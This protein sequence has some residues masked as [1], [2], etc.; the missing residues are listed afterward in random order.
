MRCRGEIYRAVNGSRADGP[1]SQQRHRGASKETATD[2]VTAPGLRAP[3]RICLSGHPLCTGVTPCPECFSAL[4]QMVIVPA[5]QA[6]DRSVGCGVCGGEAT[7]VLTEESVP[8]FFKAYG[9]KRR[10]LALRAVEALAS[11][12]LITPPPA[13]SGPGEKSL[14]G[15]SPEATSRRVEKRVRKKPV[16]SAPRVAANG[17]TAG[18]GSSPAGAHAA[19]MTSE[20]RE[21]EEKTT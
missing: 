1:D 4:V 15:P 12:P 18:E 13:S 19:D 10:E 14:E 21:R 17:I 8:A 6:M 11:Q 16:R 9:E 7:R 5:I 2:A 3:G 20:Q